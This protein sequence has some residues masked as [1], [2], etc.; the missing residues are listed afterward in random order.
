MEKQGLITQGEAT[1]QRYL[2]ALEKATPAQI[3]SANR[4]VAEHL[5]EYGH[6]FARAI[7]NGVEGANK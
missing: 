4:I 3:E 2:E 1:H 5:S 6:S 7:I